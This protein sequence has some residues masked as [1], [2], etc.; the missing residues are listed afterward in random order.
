MWEELLDP[1]QAALELAWQAYCDDCYPIG[2]VVTDAGGMILA[3]GR[4]RVYPKRLW[5]GHAPGVDIAHAEV[6]ALRSL[7]YAGIDPHTC[8]LYTTTEPCA[9]CMGAFY[10]SGLRTLHYAARDPYAGGIDL[11]G[12]TWYLSHK[13]IQVF[14]HFDPVLEKILMAMAIEQDC[15]MHAGELVENLVYQ[16]WAEVLPDAVEL[17]KLLGRSGELCAM[18]KK[19]ADPGEVFNWLITLVQ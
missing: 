19:G 4:N 9:M 2:A 14:G 3:R 10:M 6:E 7:N 13:P 17:G 1:W 15:S 18:R 12:K 11:L 5:A 8:C 16:R